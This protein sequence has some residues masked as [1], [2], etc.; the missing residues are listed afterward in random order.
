MTKP[1]ALEGLVGGTHL[2]DALKEMVRG[3]QGG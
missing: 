1:Q 3:A 2:S